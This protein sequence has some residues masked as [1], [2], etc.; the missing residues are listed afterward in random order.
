[1]P[2]R[3]FAC[4]VTVLVVDAVEIIDAQ[5][6][7]HVLHAGGFGLGDELVEAAF[8]RLP[9]Q[10]F[11]APAL[12]VGVAER[13]RRL[14]GVRDGVRVV[15][16]AEAHGAAERAPG[17][18]EDRTGGDEH[19]DRLV[20]V[21]DE[22][23]LLD[24]RDA[25]AGTEH[26]RQEVAQRKI[27]ELFGRILEQRRDILEPF[28]DQAFARSAQQRCRRRAHADD[29]SGGVGDQHGVLDRVEHGI[30]QA[31]RGLLLR[32]EPRQAVAHAAVDLQ[33]G[34]ELL[35]ALVVFLRQL[36]VPCV[37]V[38]GPLAQPARPQL[39]PQFDE[40]LAYAA[41]PYAVGDQ[42][43]QQHLE[44]SV[45]LD[46]R[47]GGAAIFREQRAQP[48][49]QQQPGG[50]QGEGDQQQPA[51]Q[52]TRALASQYPDQRPRNGHA[53]APLGASMR[54]RCGGQ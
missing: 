51:L 2:Q 3:L 45:Q 50:E 16:P 15:G 33:Q 29:G 31:Q 39:A 7:Q 44:R 27:A 37:T 34:I 25:G 43:H 23:R 49:L 42:Q 53:L 54:W 17:A 47:P 28:T 36:L 48:E 8:E 24:L 30:A 6:Q 19:R 5:I 32:G 12:H 1:M 40:W 35:A 18:I 41:P 22:H 52:G 9:R 11:G 13:Q 4:P 20:L 46:Q 21:V 10:Q 14:L 38:S 26:P